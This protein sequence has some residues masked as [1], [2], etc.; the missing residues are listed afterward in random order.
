[1]PAHL[2]YEVT[3]SIEEIVSDPEVARKVINTIEESLS[4]IEEKAREQKGIIK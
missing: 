3:K 1:M 4:A 2:P